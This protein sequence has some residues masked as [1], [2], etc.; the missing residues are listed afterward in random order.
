MPLPMFFS[1]KFCKVFKVFDIHQ[2]HY[3]T[4][5]SINCLFFCKVYSPFVLYYW[6]LKLELGVHETST[7]PLRYTWSLVCVCFI[8]FETRYHQLFQTAL[9]LLLSCLVSKYLRNTGFYYQTQISCLFYKDEI[10]RI[11]CKIISIL[12]LFLKSR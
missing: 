7:P 2:Q 5:V 12:N 9:N 10:L 1:Y 8:N 11:L 6:G 4:L 3:E